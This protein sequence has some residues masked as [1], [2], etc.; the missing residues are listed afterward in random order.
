MVFAT[1][2]PIPRQIRRV[3]LRTQHRPPGSVHGN[4]QTS[5]SEGLMSEETRKRLE[6]ARADALRVHDSPQRADQL[7]R[8]LDSM[9]R[10]APL[11]GLGEERTTRVLASIATAIR[12]LRRDD[13]GHEAARHLQDALKQ[14]DVPTRK[15]S[16]FLDD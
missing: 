9:T 12:V 1:L 11:D 4:E 6:S 7:I 13:D 8:Q 10:E 14:F 15:P 16:P 2:Y 3:T 5:N